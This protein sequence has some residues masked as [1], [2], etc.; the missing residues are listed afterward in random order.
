MGRERH[1]KAHKAHRGNVGTRKQYATKHRTRDF[2]Q[3]VED[4]ADE[5]RVKDLTV[6]DEDLPGGAQYY[7]VEC[8]KYFIRQDVLDRHKESHSHKQRVMRLRKDKPWTVE[9]ARVIKTDNGAPLGRAPRPQ[10]FEDS[11]AL[12]YQRGE[13]KAEAEADGMGE[14]EPQKEEEEKKKKAEPEVVGD[15]DEDEDVE[16]VF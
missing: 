15:E 10:Q 3:V 6:F 5:K 1:G 7:C 8:C 11:V 2:D 9:D 16:M 13:V 12:Q 14:S 4:A